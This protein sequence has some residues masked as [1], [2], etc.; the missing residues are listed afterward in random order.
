MIV[1]VFGCLVVLAQVAMG[2]EVETKMCGEKK[3]TVTAYEE[4]C[5]Y[6]RNLGKVFTNIKEDGTLSHVLCPYTKPNGCPKSCS[7]IYSLKPNS[8]SGYYNITTPEGRDKTVY[9]E[10]EGEKCEGGGW[11]QVV[12]INMTQPGTECPQG[13]T[14]KEY[15]ELPHGL[16]AIS[17]SDNS[18]DM[19]CDSTSFH[20]HNISFSKVCG[21]VY[22]YQHGE[23]LSFSTET[24]NLLEPYTTGVSISRDTEHIWTFASGDDETGQGLVNSYCPCI[25]NSVK[26]PDFVNED[27]NCESGKEETYL[28]YDEYDSNTILYVNDVLWDGEQYNS[29]EGDCPIK[30]WFQKQLA[31]ITTG[32]IDF[33]LC[34]GKPYC[35]DNDD[36]CEY[37]ETPIEL[38]ELYIK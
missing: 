37:R 27:Y 31:Q 2:F 8:T 24:N 21:R 10:M 16:C 25:E 5:C 15:K 34:G 18:P 32:D 20:T 7:D 38:I 6:E 30:N 29:E 9:C 28:Y 36:V 33:R 26:P 4:L 3:R 11:T 12:Y 22:G 1:C 17:Y 23:G 35:P 13:L 19:I 14:E